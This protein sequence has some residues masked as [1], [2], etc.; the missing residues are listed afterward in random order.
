VRQFYYDPNTGLLASVRDPHGDYEGYQY[1]NGRLTDIFAS[2]S[3]VRVEG[4]PLSNLPALRPAVRDVL[5]VSIEGAPQD[6]TVNIP[7]FGPIRL[8]GIE[9]LLSAGA[10]DPIALEELESRLQEALEKIGPKDLLIVCPGLSP[11]QVVRL[12]AALQT[13]DPVSGRRISRS[14]SPV[15]KEGQ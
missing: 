15:P 8:K 2:R 12:Q 9:N 6:L 13:I 1:S 3:E 4:R 7:D 10:E 11:L 5:E 14:G